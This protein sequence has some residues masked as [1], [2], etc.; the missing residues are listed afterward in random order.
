MMAKIRR[1][2]DYSRFDHNRGGGEISWISRKSAA[3]VQ[4]DGINKT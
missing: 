2:L 1:I 4:L 3:D